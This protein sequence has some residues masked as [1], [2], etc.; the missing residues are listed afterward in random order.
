MKTQ[1]WGR[2][3]KKVKM[4]NRGEG[5]VDKLQAFACLWT[6]VFDLANRVLVFRGSEFIAHFC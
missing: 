3:Q 2:A 4:W 5:A 6:E 1:H